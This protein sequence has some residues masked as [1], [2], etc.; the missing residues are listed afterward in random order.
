MSTRKK[1]QNYKDYSKDDYIKEINNKP[2]SRDRKYMIKQLKPVFE[3]FNKNGN[4]EI[5]NFCGIF[6]VYGLKSEDVKKFILE[7]K[8][9][10]ETKEDIPKIDWLKSREL[11]KSNFNDKNAILTRLAHEYKDFIIN[12]LNLFLTNN[13]NN[14][15][16]KENLIK[17]FNNLMN[18]NTKTNNKTVTNSPII[19]Q[20]QQQPK[21]EAAAEPIYNYENNDL[22]LQ[23]F[24]QS[25]E[26][27][28]ENMNYS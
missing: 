22:Y 21:P 19:Q 2:T 17:S 9:Q 14:F 24:E 12:I 6:K 20:Q 16:V 8:N 11:N 3:Y 13:Y 18:K 28:E 10:I 5:K 15:Y 1:Y 27:F 7:I 4:I 26:S 23:Y 25:D